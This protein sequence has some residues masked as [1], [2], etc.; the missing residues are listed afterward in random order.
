[1]RMLEGEETGKGKD[2]RHD[3]LLIRRK[4]YKKIK[5]SLVHPIQ[6]VQNLSQNL[7]FG[8]DL[9]RPDPI[10]DR[11]MSSS[12][13]ISL[14]KQIRGWRCMAGWTSLSQWNCELQHKIF[15]NH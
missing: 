8:S 11:L 9:N 13:G 2:K 15:E 6:V 7:D 12:K 1:M 5:V 10:F 14:P 4:E 3:P